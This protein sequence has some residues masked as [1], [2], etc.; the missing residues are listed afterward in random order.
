M[1][2][3][4]V[5][6][7]GAHPGVALSGGECFKG[8]AQSSEPGG[9]I[10]LDAVFL[11]HTPGKECRSI[12]AE[13]KQSRIARSLRTSRSP[14]LVVIHAHPNGPH[15]WMPVGPVGLGISVPG[16][17]RMRFSH[18]AAEPGLKRFWHRFWKGVLWHVFSPYLSF[19]LLP[20]VA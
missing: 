8:R 19:S 6:T 12:F 2:E 10:N 11:A 5:V 4:T 20:E 3:V 18:P 16:R 15:F 1:T 17:L 14:D 7:H 13:A 9:H